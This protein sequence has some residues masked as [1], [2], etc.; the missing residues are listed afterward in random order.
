MAQEREL[1]PLIGQSPSFLEMVEEVSR[2]APLDRPVLAIGERGTGKEL[3]AARIHF[4]SKR[5]NGPFVKL[6]CAAL[7][8]ELL[9]SELFGHEAGAFTG[10]QRRRIGRFELADGGTLFLDEIANASLPVQEKVLR[11]SEYGEFERVG[12]N[13]TVSV[14]VRIIGATNVD[15][16]EAAAAGRFRQDLLDRLAFDVV[17]LPPLRYRVEDIPVLT[18]HFARLFASELALPSVPVFTRA[19]MQALADYD[20]PGNVRELKNVV[21]R[22]VYRAADPAQPI[23]DII[24]DPFLSPYRP[25]AQKLLTGADV[26]AEAPKPVAEATRADLK[27]AV[28]DFERRLIEQAL[29][30]A[31]FNQRRAADDLRLTYDQLRNKLRK[32]GLAGRR[33]RP[34]SSG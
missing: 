3:I 11:V 27:A 8:A 17:T 16:P 6:N 7:S 9:E 13:A 18:H 21:E 28:A 34:D 29:E 25:L 5:W 19:A 12:G 2:L 15:L 32:Y 22:A 31:K 30:A 26:P 1:P 4:L 24:F 20:W 23:A 14:D 10:A 33:V